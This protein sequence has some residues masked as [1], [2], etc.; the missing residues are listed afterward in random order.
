MF[1][2]LIDILID[3]LW[4]TDLVYQMKIIIFWVIDDLVHWWQMVSIGQN[5]L[6]IHFL[7]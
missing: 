2:I 1:Y 3:M 6:I 4:L 5:E 7:M